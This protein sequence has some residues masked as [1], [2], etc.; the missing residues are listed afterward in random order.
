MV[1]IYVQPKEE[2][3]RQDTGFPKLCLDLHT[4]I[5]SQSDGEAKSLPRYKEGSFGRPQGWGAGYNPNS[6]NNSFLAKICSAGFEGQ[7][8]RVPEYWFHCKV[9]F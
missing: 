2:G 4:V 1:I 3:R 8:A 5:C 7:L 6:L 9:H